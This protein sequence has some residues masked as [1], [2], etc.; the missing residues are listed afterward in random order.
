MYGPIPDPGRLYTSVDDVYGVAYV[1]TCAK[2]SIASYNFYCCLKENGYRFNEKQ[3]NVTL[4]DGVP[5]T[6][7]VLTVN[8][9][10]T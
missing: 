10:V 4:A 7:T 6:Q 1:D 3:V 5:K 2:T 8:V 9:P